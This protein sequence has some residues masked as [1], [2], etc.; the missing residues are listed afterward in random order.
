MGLLNG[1]KAV[2]DNLKEKVKEHISE[3]Y[4]AAAKKGEFVV[5]QK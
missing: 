3:D 1:M 5:T 4:L 2:K